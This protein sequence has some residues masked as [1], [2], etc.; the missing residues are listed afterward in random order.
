MIGDLAK[1]GLK[2]KLNY[3]QYTAFLENV[4]KGRTPVA[5]GTWGSNSIPDVSAMTAHFFLHGPDDLTKDPEVKKLIDEADSLTDP[6][7]RKAVWQKVLDPHRR[8]G[9]LGAAVHLRQV[10]RVLQGPRLHA[11]VRR[12]PAVLRGEVEVSGRG[13]V[14]PTAAVTRTR[15]RGLTPVCR[16]SPS[17]LKRLGV[18]LLVALTVSLITFSMIYV[19]GDP[20]IAIAGEGARARTSRRSASSTASTGRSP[21][22][23]STGWPARCRATSAAPTRCASR[24]PT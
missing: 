5:H 23:I 16:C 17:Q 9:L 22:S 18:A 19:S 4:R 7:Q 15:V 8:R 11:D 24:S 1:V 14:N 13:G 6:E 2:P 12:D 20:A 21:C 10:L 3:M